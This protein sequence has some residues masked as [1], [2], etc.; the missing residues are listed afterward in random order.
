AA[1]EFA[2]EPDPDE[3]EHAKHRH[4]DDKLSGAHKANEKRHRGWYQKQYV[5]KVIGSLFNNGKR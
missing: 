2:L 1:L 5:V 4:C 3:S